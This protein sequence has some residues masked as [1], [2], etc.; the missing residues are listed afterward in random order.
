MALF[1]DG[2]KERARK[3]KSRILFPEPEDERILTACRILKDEGLA[4]PLLVG[5]PEKARTVSAGKG[6]NLMDISF[7]NPAV[8]SEG[9]NLG[10]E[11]YKI[12][13]HK[14]ISPEEADKLILDPM[15]FAA[16]LLYSGEAD[17]VVA[18]A[19]HP[20][21]WT[22]KPLLQIL[23]KEPGINYV[24]SYFVMS[25]PNSIYGH[26]GVFI[27]ADCG[28]I[29][30]PDAEQLAEIAI[31]SADT[32]QNLFEIEPKVA[33]LSFSTKGSG[34]DPLTVKVVDATRIANQKR[35]DLAIEG[36]LQVDAAMVPEVAAKKMA[37]SPVAGKANVLI[38]PDLN[39][40]NISYKL[41]QRLANAEAWGPLVQGL[42]KAASDLSRG[43]SVEDIIA[44]ST[45][46]AVQA[47]R[48][49]RRG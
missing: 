29:T 20:T 1:L 7:F 42:S 49:K 17:G 6:I 35:P 37:D 46:V 38:F 48:L 34:Y 12:R 19:S 27:Y 44:V 5:D 3:E 33:L 9:G 25:V 45:I 8:D 41:T 16:M 39:S 18:G 2:L 21:A 30:N 10:K 36:E 31:A 26:K 22:F 24:S 32:A 15:Y 11:L 13:R 14:G 23:P 40:G 47:Q 43:C 28:L 4:E